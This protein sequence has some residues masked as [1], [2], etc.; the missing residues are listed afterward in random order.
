MIFR[1]KEL[2]ILRFFIFVLYILIGLLLLLNNLL[3]FIV[4]IVKKVESIK[5][6]GRDKGNSIGDR[7]EVELD[8]NDDSRIIRKRSSVRNNVTK[9]SLFNSHEKLE[10]DSTSDGEPEIAKWLANSHWKHLDSI[11]DSLHLNV[12]V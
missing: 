8:F 4:I 9:V 7:P 1:F 5:A 12:V 3:D 10:I 6:T 2:L 11:K